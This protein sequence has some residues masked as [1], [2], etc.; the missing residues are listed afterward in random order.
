[1]EKTTP[2]NFENQQ[3]QVDS[4]GKA[5]SAAPITSGTKDA[6]GAY[7]PSSVQTGAFTSFST[8][9]TGSVT[10]SSTPVDEAV[11]NLGNNIKKAS[12]STL[13]LTGLLESFR[14]RDE[15]SSKTAGELDKLYQ[16]R[17]D[18]LDKRR[19]EELARLNA[20]YGTEKAK[21]EED[22]AKTTEPINRRLEL[23]KDTPYGP[24]AS[25][26]EEL[27]LKL[28][29]L[30]KTHKLEMDTLF[31]QRQSMIALAQSNYED[32]NFSLAESQIKNA[33]DTEK[34]IYDR[35]MD[36]FNLVLAA[37]Q[38]QRAQA[39]ADLA[40]QKEI[41]DQE[42]ERVDF[43]SKQG[44][45]GEFYKYPGSDA[46]YSS[47]NPGVPLSAEQYASMGGAGEAGGYKDVQEVSPQA[48]RDYVDNLAKTYPDTVFP[49]MTA[50]QAQKAM[51]YSKI[52]QDKVRPPQGPS[53]PGTYKFTSEDNG[54]LLAAGLTG[55]EITAIQANL[56]NGV[57]INTIL[58]SSN[59]SDSEKKA[60]KDV[61]GNVTSTQANKVAT[62]DM[63]FSSWLWQNWS[64][65]QLTKAAKNTDLGKNPDAYIEK[66][67]KRAKQYRDIGRSDQEIMAA[68]ID[69]VEADIN[70]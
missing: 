11:N 13:D 31:N 25:I 28:A 55:P 2:L 43:L 23:L 34:M 38:E 58:N 8:P 68:L 19:E 6:S 60:V 56:N 54:R 18:T 33:K 21:K 40:K 70:K 47:K 57:D 62:Y 51:Q 59:L 1:M 69:S 52:Y 4:S 46:V 17:L 5:V 67:E 39:T 35:Q 20:E 14:Q 37:Q 42:K 63:S 27:K 30:E 36:Y 49:T 29:S 10:N 45:V 48:E 24:N 15:Q 61:M 26:E 65:D 16:T 32:K 41:N 7:V 50:V 3:V 44:I 9:T 64:R 66:I 12:S 53:A 22:F